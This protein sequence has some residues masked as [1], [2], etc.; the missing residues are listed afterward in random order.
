M[1]QARVES[2]QRQLAEQRA[3]FESLS[4]KFESVSKVHGGES[5]HAPSHARATVTV[6]AIPL[7][8]DASSW[9]DAMKRIRELEL[10]KASCEKECERGRVALEQAL[11]VGAV[12]RDKL[13]HAEATAKADAQARLQAEGQAG[14][15]D[16][17]LRKEREARASLE[18]R[19]KQ[20]SSALDALRAS[21]GSD[22][23]AVAAELDR[24]REKLRSSQ[25]SVLEA[26]QAL[27]REKTHGEAQLTAL[28]QRSEVQVAEQARK[29]QEV[30][31]KLAAA[32]RELGRA[33]GTHRA[34]LEELSAL[35]EQQAAVGAQGEAD[36]ARANDVEL[37]LR[38]T[39]ERLAGV[40]SEMERLRKSADAARA[41]AAAS[42][43]HCRTLSQRCEEFESREA[44]MAAD[45]AS[46]RAEL[47]SAQARAD[48][49]EADLRQLRKSSTEALQK[50]ERELSLARKRVTRADDDAAELA[51]LLKAAR[52]ETVAVKEEVERERGAMAERLE[53]LAR[54]EGEVQVAT[55]KLLNA[56][57]AMERELTCMACLEVFDNPVT[58]I[59][60][61]HI[62]C[63]GCE[64]AYRPS[65]E[66][67]GTATERVVPD[68][69]LETLGGKCSFIKQEIAALKAMA[70]GVEM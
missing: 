40:M 21:A 58:L 55:A 31:G 64:T 19:L 42:A 51:Q 62:F 15:L 9:S 13:A 37:Q 70:G 41:E 34:Q 4:R 16:G 43:E 8:A 23:R 29:I 2:V 17:M 44:S 65:C 54:Q 47:T 14:A 49:A 33:A 39:T 69:R 25:Q 28:Q 63:S 6:G 26:N 10:G 30:S 57:E 12:L 18:T 59:P 11:A 36:R 38:E 67:C 50:V 27:Q 61:G 5:A 32:E 46:L 52:A 66:E 7:T 53:L 48:V 56:E 1:R 20:Q 24:V 22:A 60:C 35:R 45:A 3:R 68:S